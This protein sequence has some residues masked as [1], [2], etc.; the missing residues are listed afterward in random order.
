MGIMMSTASNLKAKFSKVAGAHKGVTWGAALV[1]SMLGPSSAWAQCADN[2]NI[3]VA[4]FPAPGQI[5]P[6]TV[7]LPLGV[8]STLSALT[9]TINSV[10]TAFLTTTS[11]FV[12]GPGNAQPDQQGGGVWTRTVAGFVET[13][14]TS[15]STL[16]VPPALGLGVAT[17][18]QT[19]HSTTRQDYF[20]YQF[21]HDISVLNV[22]GTGANI[23]FGATAG[24]F[25]AR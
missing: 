19:C 18:T 20:G 13:D 1:A 5:S 2:F 4:N 12:S 23:H 22:G 25:E 24:Y 7:A 17:G 21:G 3:A 6:A 11:A 9:S 15:R 10:N 8:G 16:T 14:S